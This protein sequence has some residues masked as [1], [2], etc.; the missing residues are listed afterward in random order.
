M[1]GDEGTEPNPNAQYKPARS[2]KH[3]LSRSPLPPRERLILTQVVIYHTI[4]TLVLFYIE[5][6]RLF[7]RS[8]EDGRGRQRA[9]DAPEEVS[10]LSRK[11]RAKLKLRL[12]VHT[13]FQAHLS[14]VLA[15]CRIGVVNTLSLQRQGIRKHNTPFILDAPRHQLGIQHT[16]TSVAST[17]F[18]AAL[19]LYIPEPIEPSAGYSG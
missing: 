17:H 16:H 5:V 4:L 10:H 13:Y 9:R 7:L 1:I 8:N 14:F 15:L 18:Y 3:A 2:I 6:A 11:Q 12:N 19:L